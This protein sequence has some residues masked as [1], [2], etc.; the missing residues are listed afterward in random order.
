MS[1]QRGVT[2]TRPPDAS[3]SGTEA[4]R[5]RHGRGQHAD[6]RRAFWRRWRGGTSHAPARETAAMRKGIVV[7]EEAPWA[8]GPHSQAVVANGFVFV[9]GQI[10][11]DPR[12]EQLI[13]GDVRAQTT[14]VMNNIKAILEAAGSSIDRV[15]KT[16][17]FLRDLNDFYAMNESY[18]PYF[19]EDPPARSVVQVSRLPRGAGVQI[20]VVA[21]ADGPDRGDTV[22]SGIRGGVV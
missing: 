5:E 1:P 22:M 10:A 15:T 9:S 14:R 13:L 17:V 11:L 19:Q 12:T 4:V 3:V 7:T 2:E 16:T 18:Y 21:L 8:I 20:E 6:G